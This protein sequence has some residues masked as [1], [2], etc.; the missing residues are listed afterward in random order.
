VTSDGNFDVQQFNSL[1]RES[2][3]EAARH[4]CS[5]ASVATLLRMHAAGIDQR[6]L[7]VHTG[8]Q[9]IPVEMPRQSSGGGEQPER[10]SEIVPDQ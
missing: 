8:R 7:D 4:G 9:S 10:A 6:G 3:H 5:A 2:L 1:L